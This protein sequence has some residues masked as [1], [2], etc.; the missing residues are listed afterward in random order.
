MGNGH[1]DA[2]MGFTMLA[3]LF[4]V[5]AQ[6]DGDVKWKKDA[7][8]LRN[9]YSQVGL[10]CK[11]ASDPSWNEAKLRGEE[12]NALLSGGGVELPKKDLPDEWGKLVS[13]SVLMK[14]M[15]D[16]RANKL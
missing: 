7:R 11:T 4:G 14:R 12:L 2:R 9:K 15:E 8:A 16:A 6:Y 5:A 13:R 1:D 3:S 10:N